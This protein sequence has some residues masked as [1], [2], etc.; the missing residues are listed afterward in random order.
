VIEE[1]TFGLPTFREFTIAAASSADSLL[2]ETIPLISPLRTAI[3]DRIWNR[4]INPAPISPT[5]SFLP[6]IIPPV[7]TVKE[8]SQSKGTTEQC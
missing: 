1:N 6:E 2:R 5:P 8:L 4:A 7:Y 3:H